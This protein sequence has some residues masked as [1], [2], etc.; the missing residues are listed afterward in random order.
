MI[1][2]YIYAAQIL[3]GVYWCVYTYM[4]IYI[5]VYALINVTLST[6]YISHVNNVRI[7][8]E[9]YPTIPFDHFNDSTHEFQWTQIST[10]ILNLS[11]DIQCWP[12]VITIYTFSLTGD[13]YFRGCCYWYRIPSNDTKNGV[14]FL[15]TSDTTLHSPKC[16]NYII[17][18]PPWHLYKISNA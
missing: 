1:Q 17:V 16:L 14:L 9:T 10:R 7:I 2:E 3:C 6:K 5:R 12:Y 8:I 15:T 4:S 13:L 18:K 11:T